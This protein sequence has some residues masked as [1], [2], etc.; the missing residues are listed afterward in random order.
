MAF[1][2]MLPGAKDG[3]I[4]ISHLF[5]VHTPVKSDEDEA[6]VLSNNSAKGLSN[7][8]SRRGGTTRKEVV[9]P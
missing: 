7:S 1:K 2:S 8:A 6:M 9:L 5:M 3:L 4:L